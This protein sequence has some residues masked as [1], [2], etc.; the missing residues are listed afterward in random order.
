V[1]KLKKSKFL[2]EPVVIEATPLDPCLTLMALP[3][4]GQARTQAQGGMS[5]ASLSQPK[6]LVA[7]GGSR[8]K[9]TK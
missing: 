7:D 6:G 2:V 1:S 4:S 3:T 9:A 5:E 8:T